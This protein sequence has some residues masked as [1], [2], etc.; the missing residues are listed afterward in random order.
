[1]ASSLSSK[2]TILCTLLLIFLVSNS[3]VN[4]IRPGRMTMRTMKQL[5]EDVSA[6]ALR[7]LRDDKQKLTPADRLVFTKLP[8]GVPIPPSAPSKRHNSEP[9]D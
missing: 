5:E 9:E 1:M 3:C 6:M 7:L 8:K 2:T 4:A